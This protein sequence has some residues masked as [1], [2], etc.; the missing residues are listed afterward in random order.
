MNNA[1]WLIPTLPLF[2]FAILLFMPRSLRNRMLLI[3]PLSLIISSCLALLTVLLNLSGDHPLEP[4]YLTTLSLGT[5]GGVPLDITFVIDSLSAVMLVTVGVIATC[6]QIYSIDYMRDDE[7]RGWFF[8]IMSLLTAAM[9]ALVM[10]GDLLLAFAMWEVMGVSSYLLIGFWFRERAPRQASQKAFLYTRAAD[11]GF[12]IALAAIFTVGRTFQIEEIL[13]QAS[14]WPIGIVVVASLGLLIAAMGK[15]AQF[16]FNVWLPDAMVGPTPGLALADAAAKV[17]AGVFVIARMLPMFALVPW[18]LT[19]ISWIGLITAVLGAALACFQDDLKYVLAFST[20]SQLGAMFI[21]LGAGSA[22]VAIFHLVTHAFFKSLLFL[23]AGLVI[24]AVRTQDIRKM[25]GL[26]RRLP[27]TAAL[28]A[29]GAFALAGLFPLSGFFSKDEVFALVLHG[30]H[31]VRFA[32]AYLMGTLTSLYVVKTFL[33]VFFGPQKADE[34]R[35][36]SLLELIPASVL[37]AV[38]LL[39]GALTVTLSEYLGHEGHWPSLQMLLISTSMLLIGGTLGIL[40]YRGIFDRFKAALHPTIGVAFEHRLYEDD[41]YEHAIIKPFVYLSDVLARF[42]HSVID[43]VINGIAALYRRITRFARRFDARIIDG[44][45]DGVA[46]LYRHAT[47]LASR[48]DALIVDGFV[49]SV[50][51]GYVALTGLGK[52]LDYYLIDGTVHGIQRTALVIGNGLRTV[53]DGRIKTYQLVALAGVVLLL[54]WA[55]LSRGSG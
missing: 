22:T 29:I 35:Q 50:G 41:L 32:L 30:G 46:S 43:G 49:D 4:F 12:F 9:L 25:G 52:T 18:M 48:F 16:P 8:A 27:W 34:I 24:Y 38:T 1:V 44:V 51:A 17:T 11:C 3:A 14:R 6:V 5:I 40:A 39:G 28:F 42:D 53:Q 26:A 19:L 33:R 13:T 36:P 31:P 21:A 54:L 20:V 37:A 23:T 2:T 55:I 47:R 45:I 15:S 10:A 7:R